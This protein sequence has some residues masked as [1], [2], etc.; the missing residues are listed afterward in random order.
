[1]LQN[2]EELVEL[3]R[4]LRELCRQPAGATQAYAEAA[5][6][7]QAIE[8]KSSNAGIWG[9]AKEVESKAEHLYR[10]PHLQAEAVIHFM[11][12]ERINRLEAII[13]AGGERRSPPIAAHSSA[14]PRR[15]WTDR[16]IA[17]AYAP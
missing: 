6:L 13:R 17:P 14:V 1:M 7:L 11:L 3:V 9:L 12:H 16:A 4:K 2:Q 8:A 10:R 15:R 5:A